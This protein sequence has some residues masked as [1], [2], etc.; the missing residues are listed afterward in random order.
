MRNSIIQKKA[1]NELVEKSL[2][3]NNYKEYSD[4]INPFEK[5]T[6][7]YERFKRKY[8]RYRPR[9][10]DTNLIFEDLCEVYGTILHRK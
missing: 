6:V 3:K 10:M 2:V 1:D 7:R 8:I 9:R 4:D 5:E